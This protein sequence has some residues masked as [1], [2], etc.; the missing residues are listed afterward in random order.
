V[1]RRDTDPEDRRAVS[2]E[3]TQTGRDLF[4]Q[5]YHVLH[6]AHLVVLGQFLV[7]DTSARRFVEA[8]APDSRS[9]KGA[10]KSGGAK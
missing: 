8:Y 10:A 3:L 7:Q 5:L 6:G 1:R 9:S 2:V 4:P